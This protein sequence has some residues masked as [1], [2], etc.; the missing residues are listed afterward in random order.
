MA[1][2]AVLAVLS[3]IGMFIDNSLVKRLLCNISKKTTTRIDDWIVDILY[4]AVVAGDKKE[5]T[6]A[7]LTQVQEAYDKASPEVKEDMTSP[8]RMLIVEDGTITF[9]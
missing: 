5:E 2:T 3:T 8:G 7:K 9:K 4:T 6:E 1:V